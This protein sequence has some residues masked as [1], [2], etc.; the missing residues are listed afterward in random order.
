MSLL[1][2]DNY[3][4][5]YLKY[6]TKYL[7]L[8]T[9]LK[10]NN[11]LGGGVKTAKKYF[12]DKIIKDHDNI[13]DLFNKDSFFKRSELNLNLKLLP[14]IDKTTTVDELKEN[15]LLNNIFEIILT[16]SGDDIIDEVCKIY[17]NGQLGFLNSLE[18]IGRYKDAQ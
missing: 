16:I 15:S 8:Q 6:K 11:L 5:K 12:F 10:I 14:I 13:Y 18:N 3:K 1:S 17:L 9:K 2:S 4:I 7:E